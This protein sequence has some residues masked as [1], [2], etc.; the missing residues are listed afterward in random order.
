MFTQDYRR[1]SDLWPDR[2]LPARPDALDAESSE[3]SSS[4]SSARSSP[5][6]TSGRSTP[7]GGRRILGDGPV[8]KVANFAELEQRNAVLYAVAKLWGSKLARAEEIVEAQALLLRT[9]REHVE[10]ELLVRDLGLSSAMPTSDGAFEEEKE[11]GL[12][13]RGSPSPATS[14]AARSR[15]FDALVKMIP[16]LCDH[17]ENDVVSGISRTRRAMQKCVAI[18]K[19]LFKDTEGAVDDAVQA[20]SSPFSAEQHGD[21]DAFRALMRLSRIALAAQVS[22]SRRLPVIFKIVVSL[23]SPTAAWPGRNGIDSG[24]R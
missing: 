10:L 7:R 3:D 13:A 18:R 12:R 1:T 15:A 11:P 23:T 14:R 24:R 17:L 9:R 21:E 4:G 5:R 16:A 2:E 6:P 19:K 20:R 22:T 8:V